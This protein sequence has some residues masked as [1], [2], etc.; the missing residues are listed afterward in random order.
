MIHFNTMIFSNLH[1]FI[2]MLS[3]D[4]PAR[5]TISF[6]GGIPLPVFLSFFLSRLTSRFR[7]TPGSRSVMPY[8]EFPARA[9]MTGQKYQA[10]KFVKKIVG[11]LPRGT[12][13]LTN[14][15]GYFTNQAPTRV[16]KSPEGLSLFSDHESQYCHNQSC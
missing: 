10:R 7:G 15:R 4:S 16:K 6:Q 5:L 9:R 14:P 2:V 3:P 8:T 11:S 13:L 1:T 12:V